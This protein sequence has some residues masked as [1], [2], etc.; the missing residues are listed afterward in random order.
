MSQNVA[1]KW[2]KLDTPNFM[3]VINF[4]DSKKHQE[5]ISIRVFSCWV[6]GGKM[7]MREKYLSSNGRRAFYY[8]LNY[9]LLI[10]SFESYGELE[11]KLY[12]SVSVCSNF[13]ISTK[14][15]HPKLQ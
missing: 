12:N 1:P 7:P 4:V 2:L 15:F 6:K 9:I 3:F 11:T 10:S 14:M 13:S 8:P 5:H